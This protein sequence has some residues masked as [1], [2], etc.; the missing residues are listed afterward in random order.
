M[1]EI[2]AS[3][4]ASIAP[5]GFVVPRFREVLAERLSAD[6]Q[7]NEPSFVKAHEAYRLPGGA[8]LFSRTGTA[9]VVYLVRNPL[10]V[11]VPYA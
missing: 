2:S 5:R 6:R 4:R 1:G 10:D 3:W 8:P 7:R 9:G 11:A